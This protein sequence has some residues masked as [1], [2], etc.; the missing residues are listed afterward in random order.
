MLNCKASTCLPHQFTYFMCSMRREKEETGRME[1]IPLM[2]QEWDMSTISH[3]TMGEYARERELYNSQCEAHSVTHFNIPIKHLVLSWWMKN[4]TSIFNDDTHFT[5]AESCW[6][7]SLWYLK[8]RCIPCLITSETQDAMN[9]CFWNTFS[10][11][12]GP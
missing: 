1:N 2:K 6:T 8:W 11:G 9:F 10:K 3:W 7:L 5:N 4:F 12:K